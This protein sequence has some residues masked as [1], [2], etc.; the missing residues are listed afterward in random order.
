MKDGCQA[1]STLSTDVLEKTQNRG[2]DLI[3]PRRHPKQPSFHQNVGLNYQQPTFSHIQSYQL[4]ISIV[5]FEII[6]KSKREKSKFNLMF[7][8]YS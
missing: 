8:R 6:Y 7:L 1:L 3:C 4:V 2:K 5:G